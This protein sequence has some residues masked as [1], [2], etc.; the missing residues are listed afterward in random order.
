MFPLHSLTGSMRSLSMV[1]MSEHP[2]ATNEAVTSRPKKSIRVVTGVRR[3][4][5]ICSDASKS[6]IAEG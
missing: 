1:A 6:L 5:L 3:D 4:S 2:S